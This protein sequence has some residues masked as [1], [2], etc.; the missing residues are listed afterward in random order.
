MP[1][2]EELGTYDDQE[3]RLAWSAALEASQAGDAT[4]CDSPG[5]HSTPSALEF[6][7]DDLIALAHDVLSGTVPRNFVPLQ[8]AALALAGRFFDSAGVCRALRSLRAG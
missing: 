3:T 5:P 4:H 2:I 7:G 8:D 1:I 6:S